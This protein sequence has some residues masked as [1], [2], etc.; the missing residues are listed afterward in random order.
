MNFWTPRNLMAFF[1]FSRLHTP[2]GWWIYLHL[3]HL[4]TQM[5]VNALTIECLGKGTIVSTIYI[6]LSETQ[7]TFDIPLGDRC[8]LPRHW[9]WQAFQNDFDRGNAN[10]VML[11]PQSVI[12]NYSRSWRKRSTIPE[13][14]NWCLR[15]GP[16][17]SKESNHFPT[18]DF[19]G[20]FFGLRG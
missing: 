2:W 8:F 6:P 9:T 5:K 19:E 11:I 7:L 13:N 14:N 15:I 10:S 1:L 20:H 16:F 18:I 17:A 3:S 4:C 12:I